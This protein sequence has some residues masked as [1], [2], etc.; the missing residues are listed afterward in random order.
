MTT[1]EPL[2][3]VNDVAKWLS[4]HPNTVR[5]LGDRGAFPVYRVGSRGDRRFRLS[6]VQA[7]LTA[8][9]QNQL[10]KEQPAP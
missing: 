3:T 8:R 7:Y 10:V 5:R 1:V 4:I 9:S 6:E 2:L